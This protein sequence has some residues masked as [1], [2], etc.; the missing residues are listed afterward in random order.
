[1]W[2]NAQN[3]PMHNI[4]GSPTHDESIVNR[5]IVDYYLFLAIELFKNE[6]YSDFCGVRDILERV[7]SRP[8]ESTDLMP[9][10]IRV[11]QFL[12]RI[13]DGDKLDW[14]FESD[15]SVTPL[16]SAMRV[17]ENMSEECS[18][19]Q[20]D[21]EKVSTSIKDMVRHQ[22]R[23]LASRRPLMSMIWLKSCK[24]SRSTPFIP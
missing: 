23:A 7:L 24:Q 8:L 17:L 2:R 14:S 4:A 1:N 19:P 21:L 12:S 10:K 13:N 11:L 20:Q 15:E 22:Y 3:T 6:Q 18:I 16:E 9:T 5:W